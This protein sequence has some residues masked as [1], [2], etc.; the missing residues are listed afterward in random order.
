MK[1]IIFAVSF[2]CI[3]AIAFA[4]AIKNWSDYENELRK[5]NLTSAEAKFKSER[6][7]PKLN[8]EIKDKDITENLEWIFPVSGFTKR[9]VKNFK[10]LTSFINLSFRDP[11]FF[12]GDEFLSQP[13]LKFFIVPENLKK[14]TVLEEAVVVAANNGIVVYVKKGALNS[15][16]GNAV[17]IYNPGQNYFI[18]YGMLRT[19]DVNIGDIVSAGDKIGSI[20]PSKKGYDLNFAV[21][22]YGD[23]TFTLFNYFDEMK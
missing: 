2:A 20:K 9:D 8:E 6:L 5:G 11:K 15:I 19:V 14:N 22:M 3:S 1:K 16:G 10:K 21:L 17:W 12:E 4:D 18:Y 23:D 13:Y 7:V